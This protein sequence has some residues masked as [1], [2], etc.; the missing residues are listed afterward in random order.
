[1][2]AF[3]VH[4]E[5]LRFLVSAAARYDIRTIYPKRGTSLTVNA[6]E[7][8]G[9]MPGPLDLGAL[10][11]SRGNWLLAL[12]HAENVRSVRYRYPDAPESELPGMHDESGALLP[13]GDFWPVHNIDPVLVLKA[14]DCYDY[15][16]CETPDYDET[17]AAALVR[18]IRRAAIA[19]LPGYD[20]APWEIES[21]PKRRAAGA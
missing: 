5:H 19:E 1:M 4:P 8:A 16:A 7:W 11:P 10:R 21:E 13:P 15:Q 3:V 17:P 12:L 6:N 2:S 14:C 18:A 9:P 20:A